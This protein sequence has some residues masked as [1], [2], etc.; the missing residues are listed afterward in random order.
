MSDPLWIT[1]AD[2]AAAVDLT[3]TRAAVHAAFAA[4][5]AVTLEKTA[6]TYGVDGAAGG[7][8]ATLHALGGVTGGITG[9]KTWAHTP[10][11]AS[12]LLVLWDSAAGTLL[13][14]VEAFALGQL[15]TASV[16]AV[17]TDA[18]APPSADVLAI[19]GT[20]KQALAQVAA[21]AAVRPLR[22]VR[23]FSPTAENRQRFCHT[24]AERLPGVHVVD[25]RSVAEAADGAGVVTTATRATDAVLDNSV[26]IADAHV[27]A[28]GAI[29][30]ERRELAP[31]VVKVA[32]LV[33]SD[34]PAAATTLSAELDFADDVVPL[35][36]VVAS[37][38]ARPAGV[39]V[40]KAMGSG[41][42]DVAVGALVLERVRAAG[43]GRPFPSP[44]KAAPRLFQQL[45]GGAA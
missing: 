32:S 1:E 6:V 18:M 3:D 17:A 15:R 22:E 30:P 13:A 9:T 20:G 27:N 4:P 34:S 11:G 40:F 39:S 2:V 41:L 23:A 14:V 45:V 25:C 5:E 21:V 26:L 37:G 36:A 8:E 12:P 35:S 44:V 42:A 19:V 33:V 31:S 24:V 10:G 16:S 28:I 43:G 29:T 38:A 7:G